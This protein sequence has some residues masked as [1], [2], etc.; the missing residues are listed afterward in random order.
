MAT[1][2]L[3]GVL[4]RK[5]SS[6]RAVLSA[7]VAPSAAHTAAQTR[8]A[9]LLGFGICPSPCRL[10]LECDSARPPTCRIYLG[11]RCYGYVTRGLQ[12]RSRTRPPHGLQLEC[13]TALRVPLGSSPTGAR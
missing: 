3:I 8:V 12:Q 9:V 13:L 5:P 11:A 10:G 7:H 1:T 4:V 2:C 6:A